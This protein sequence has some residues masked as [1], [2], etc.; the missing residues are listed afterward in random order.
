MVY[1]P[2]LTAITEKLSNGVKIFPNSIEKVRNLESSPR[3]IKTHLS[4]QM[5]PI[6]IKEKKNRIIYVTRNPRDACVSLFNHFQV[7]NCYTGTF[8]DLVDAFLDDACG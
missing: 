6:Q 1:M 7:L 4:Y 2:R 5:L 3:L 8:P